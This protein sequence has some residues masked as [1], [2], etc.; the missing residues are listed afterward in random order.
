MTRLKHSG[1]EMRFEDVVE[2]PVGVEKSNNRL[3]ADAELAI[4]AVPIPKKLLPVELDIF[5]KLL[6][7][8]ANLFGVLS[9]AFVNEH[10]VL[11]L[12]LLANGDAAAAENP[13]FKTSF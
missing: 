8:E 11:L 6:V 4:A 13:V 2:L 10:F 1:V 3:A 12:L 9:L 5:V 7:D